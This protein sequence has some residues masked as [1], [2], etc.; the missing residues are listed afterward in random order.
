MFYVFWQL[1]GQGRSRAKRLGSDIYRTYMLCG[2]LTLFVW[3]CYPIAWG[4]S[5]GANL[6]APD[7]EAV[8]YGILDF[9]AKPVFS[10][11][12]IVGHWNVDPARLGLTINYGDELSTG[13]HNEKGRHA[14]GPAA[15]AN[16]GT[17]GTTTATDNAITA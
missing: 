9:L 1:A 15:T 6:I 11:A 14:A 5:E 13:H 2:V 17:N 10:A 8:F 3:L 4:V 16:N 12:L 7:S